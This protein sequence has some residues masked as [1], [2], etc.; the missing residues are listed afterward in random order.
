[1]ENFNLKKFLVENKLT[2]NSRML[3]ENHQLIINSLSKKIYSDLKDQ[4]YEV[5]LDTTR[6]STGRQSYNGM[7]GKKGEL[8][9]YD[10]ADF[11]IQVLD[12]SLTI[13]FHEKQY[14]TDEKELRD[15]LNKIKEKYTNSEMQSAWGNGERSIILATKEKID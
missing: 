5:L 1:M 11:V 3:N 8:G 14:Q 4:G 2:T 9:S 10:S 7:I 12:N 13:T 6:K 15:V